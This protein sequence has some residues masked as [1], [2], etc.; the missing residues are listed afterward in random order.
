MKNEMKPGEG[1]L[2]NRPY[3]MLLTSQLV[4]NLGDWLYLLALLTL[5]GL[6]WNATPWQ[7][8][9][10]ML[11]MLLP[12]LLGGPLAGML[13]DR[14]ERKRLMIISDL[15]RMVL[16]LGLVFVTELWQVYLLLIVKSSFDVMFSPAKNGKIK[17][18]VPHHQLEQAVSY[19][20]IIEQG[21]KIIG[22]ALGGMLSAAFGLSSSFIINSVAFLIS[23]I[24]LIGV[25][26][27]GNL[28]TASVQ[29]QEQGIG[30]LAK[31]AEGSQRG[32]FWREV[33]A[34]LKIIAG[35]P[36]IFF[37]LL[38]LASALLVLQIAD[39]Q[40]VV[41]FRGIPGVSENLLGWCITC[42]GVGTF[43][44]VGVN[45]ILRKWSPLTKM[46]FGGMLVGLVFAGAGLLTLQG[47]LGTIGTGLMLTMF[48]LAGLGAGL[49]F[50]PFQVTLQQRT[51]EA[52][53]GRVFGTVSSVTSAAAV[54][55]PLCGGYLVT[56]FG[57]EPAY[58][59]SGGLMTLIGL[60]LLLF[61][62]PIIERDQAALQT[63]GLQEDGFTSAAMN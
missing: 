12:T 37:G 7:I 45:S 6:R 14:V 13:A 19:S 11:C 40:I 50:I 49:T 28:T 20:A 30:G 52:M 21:S 26:T 41:L 16:I 61:R 10:T 36:L 18:I 57:P 25:P 58:I 34:G 27:K 4:S 23:A 53:T 38:T 3:V 22:P 35:I 39:S 15:A 63:A 9:M 29:E 46:S 51:P 55:G 31:E 54:I 8:T 42:S 62:R 24:A 59:L 17:E 48:L 33:S 60:A 56:M 1:L 43:L 5:I 32:G 44:A 2:K 47:A